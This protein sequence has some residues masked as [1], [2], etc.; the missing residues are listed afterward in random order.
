MRFQEKPLKCVSEWSCHIM[1]ITSNTAI[2]FS[3]I[4]IRKDR[5]ELE[6]FCADTNSR[7]KNFC[8]QKNVE[9]IDNE[10]LK[11]SYPGIKK[12]HLNRKNNTILQKIY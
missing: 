10:N 11:E 12:L 1:I 5:K 4:V 9:L 7:L 8:K 6:K 2:S 3:N